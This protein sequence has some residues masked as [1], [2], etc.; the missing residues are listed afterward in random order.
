VNLNPRGAPLR[1]EFVGVLDEQVRRA[2]SAVR[3]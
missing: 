3:K 1:R 2:G